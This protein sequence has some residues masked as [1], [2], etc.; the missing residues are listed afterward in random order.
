[1]IDRELRLRRIKKRLV[2]QVGFAVLCDVMFLAFLFLIQE[3]TFLADC[4][5]AALAVLKLVPLLI[6]EWWNW[7][8]AARA[9]SDMWAFG[10]L[11]FDEVSREL[12]TR[13]AIE[14]DLKDSKPYID[15]MHDQ[16]GDSLSESEREV[17]KALDE[18]K[19]AA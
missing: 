5:V 14:A 11:N 12:A 10:N 9:A 16:I 7:R 6:I 13:K 15:V 17:Q 19:K 8:M 4:I 2:L 3:R 1:M 18:L